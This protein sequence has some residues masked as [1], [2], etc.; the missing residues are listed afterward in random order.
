MRKLL[1]TL[2]CYTASVT[3]GCAQLHTAHWHLLDTGSGLSSNQVRGIT[4][5]SNGLMV[6]KT[7]E[8][9]NVYNGVTVQHYP[10]ER[11]HHYAWSYD[12]VSKEYHDHQGRVWMKAR[13]HLTLLDLHTGQYVSDITGSSPSWAWSALSRICSW[14]TSNA[15]GW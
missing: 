12:G 15:S 8:Q 3:L 14:M 13:E 9:I 1:Y 4:Q 6:I 11:T 2:F 7:T 10:Y 5:A